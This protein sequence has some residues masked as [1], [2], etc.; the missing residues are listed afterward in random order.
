[1]PQAG[2]FLRQYDGAY[3]HWCPGCLM[4]HVV[5]VG[6]PYRV[7]WE[8]NGN[9]GAPGFEPSVRHDWGAGR[10]CHYFLR[11]GRLYFCTDCTHALAGK[12]VALPPVPEAFRG[13]D[14]A[15]GG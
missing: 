7:L 1:M 3:A 5:P 11:V 15:N 6:A 4:M 14:Q 13:E 10:T 12:E 9:L 8:F 2:E